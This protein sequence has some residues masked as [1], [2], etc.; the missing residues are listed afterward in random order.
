MSAELLD[1][2]VPRSA[3]VHN[4]TAPTECAMDPPK[5]QGLLGVDVNQTSGPL[6]FETIHQRS[7][8]LK[9]GGHW[10]PAY[11]NPRNRVA[12]IIPYR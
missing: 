1:N 9:E 5:L 6:D 4:Y 10:S 2:V 8:A 12:I 7:P 11:C 3:V